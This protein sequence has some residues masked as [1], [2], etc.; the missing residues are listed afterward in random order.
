MECLATFDTTHMALRFEK[1]C[2][3]ADLSVR[4]VP[5]PRELSASCGLAC[6]YPCEAEETVR[7]LVEEHRIDVLQLHRIDGGRP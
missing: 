7:G 2:R 6:R 4:I 3:Q 5:V 1:I